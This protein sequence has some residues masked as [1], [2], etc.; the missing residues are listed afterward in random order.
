[1]AQVIVPHNEKASLGKCL[2]KAVVPPEA[3]FLYKGKFMSVHLY[4]CVRV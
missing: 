3:I 2:R 1:M 4:M